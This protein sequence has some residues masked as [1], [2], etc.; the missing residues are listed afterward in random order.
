MGPPEVFLEMDAGALVVALGQ[1]PWG[2]DGMSLHEKSAVHLLARLTDALPTPDQRSGQTAE[3][4]RAVVYRRL[5]SNF[6]MLAR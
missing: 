2:E 6:T 3:T 5:S 4:P 1:R